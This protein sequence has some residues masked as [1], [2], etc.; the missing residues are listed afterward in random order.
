MPSHAQSGKEPGTSE[1]CLF[2]ASSPFGNQT[3]DRSHSEGNL[4]RA[5]DAQNDVTRVSKEEGKK[6]RVLAQP[7][8]TPTSRMHWHS[9]TTVASRQDEEKGPTYLATR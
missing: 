5:E 7:T 1:V 9:R 3:H 4:G 8:S 6:H 2:L